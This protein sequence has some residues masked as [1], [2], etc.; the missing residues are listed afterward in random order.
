MSPELLIKINLRNYNTSVKWKCLESS[1]KPHHMFSLLKHPSHNNKCHLQK[2]RTTSVG[3]SVD[4]VTC[5]ENIESQ[6]V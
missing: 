5:M 1:Q 2:Y 4:K 6:Y 3:D